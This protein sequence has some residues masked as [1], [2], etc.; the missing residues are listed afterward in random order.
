MKEGAE[1]VHTKIQAKAESV[2]K[3][4]LDSA[5]GIFLTSNPVCICRPTNFCCYSQKRFAVLC[6]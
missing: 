1:N 2:L 3:H 5:K 4:G 6:C